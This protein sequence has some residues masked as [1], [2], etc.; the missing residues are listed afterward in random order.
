M[1]YFIKETPVQTVRGFTLVEALVAVTIL[2]LAVA[3]PLYTANQS[4]KAAETA[5]YKLT[6][7]YLAQ[8][9]V[10]YARLVRDNAYLTQF[11]G[12]DPQASVSG[13]NNFINGTILSCT[14]LN[15][16]S[17]DLSTPSALQGGAT[18]WTVYFNSSQGRYV[19]GTPSGGQ[20]AFTRKIWVEKL[21]GQIT[22]EPYSEMKVTS[23]VTFQYHG[24]PS[25]VTVTDNITLWQ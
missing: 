20:M 8:E 16:C 19:R 4:L 18:N 17:L 1:R 21:Q 3:G 24:N 25:T 9:G 7:L 6:A 11:F 22:T 5:R 23:Q 2:A 10:E 12:K 15:P 14:A 13:W